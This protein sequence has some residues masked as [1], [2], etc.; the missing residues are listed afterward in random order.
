MPQ[1]T[2]TGLTLRPAGFLTIFSQKN[3]IYMH[4][5]TIFSAYP[6]N[7][8]QNGNQDFSGNYEHAELATV[9]PHSENMRE[10]NNTRLFKRL[11]EK[12]KPKPYWK[13][14]QGIYRAVLGTSFLFNVLSALTASAVVFFFIQGLTGSMTASLAITVILLSVLE[15]MKR[16]TSAKLFHGILQFKNWNYGLLFTVIA[17]SAI[18]TTA[19]YFGAAQVV[20]SLTPPPSLTD[21]A[22]QTAGI[23]NQI[24][25]IDQQIAAAQRNTWQG[26]LTARSARTVE[27]LTE[28]RAALT[29]ELMRTR[30]RTDMQNDVVQSEHL[31]ET[32]S[33][34]STFAMFTLICEIA[35]IGCLFFMQHYDFRSF[36]EYALATNPA[37]GNTSVNANRY[38]RFASNNGQNS[39]PAYQNGYHNSV[40]TPI[41]FKY[42]MNAGTEN[43]TQTVTDSETN[44]EPR[45][46]SGLERQCEH[47]QVSY[48]HGHS[49]QR[50]CGQACRISA[51]RKKNNREPLVF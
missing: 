35:L 51:W 15:F 27:R 10:F 3:S 14:Y 37:S 29:D 43:V 41:G 46:V 20:E 7:N 23:E 49:R 12:H 45:A 21:V 24:A 19:S 26:R 40:H 11:S 28:S 42:G 38:T 1:K 8:Y 5:N 31:S 4:K 36:A 17:L 33:N 34:A 13:Q 44:S 48:I 32:M 47:C 50:Y 18:S 30:E 39:A 25:G 2:K 6:S 16:E 9:N 22:E